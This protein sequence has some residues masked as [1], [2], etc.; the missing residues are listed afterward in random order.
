MN[1][2][3]LTIVLACLF[4]ACQSPSSKSDVSQ[5]LVMLDAASHGRDGKAKEVLPIAEIPSNITVQA[6]TNYPVWREDIS[7]TIDSVYITNTKKFVSA[8]TLP[9]ILIYEVGATEPSYWSVINLATSFA[10]GGERKTLLVLPVG[11]QKSLSSPITK[12]KWA[13]MN[14]PWPMASYYSLVPSGEYEF[15]LAL[16]IYDDEDQLVDVI[17][18]PRQKYSS[19]FKS[20]DQSS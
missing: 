8:R 16:E 19:V 17:R 9:K 1:F 4:A 6:T 2:R 15:Q 3:V 13:P 11:S 10:L 5:E 20:N 7:V 14:S 18:T 12:L